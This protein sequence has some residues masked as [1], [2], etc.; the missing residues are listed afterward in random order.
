MVTIHHSVEECGILT[1]GHTSLYSSKSQ[2]VLI[3]LSVV[4]DTVSHAL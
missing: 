1:Y 2:D 4:T 3:T